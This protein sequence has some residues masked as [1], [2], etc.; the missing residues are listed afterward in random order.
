MMLSAQFQLYDVFNNGTVFSSL[1]GN[2]NK[3]DRSLYYF[4][5]LWGYTR[6]RMIIFFQ[7]YFRMKWF[8][9]TKYHSVLDLSVPL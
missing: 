8:K 1:V 4:G 3:P 7:I 2:E 9:A 6:L 5:G